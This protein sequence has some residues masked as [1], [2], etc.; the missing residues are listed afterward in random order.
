MIV[1]TD[2]LVIGGGMAAAW[3]AISAAREG[4]DVVVVDKGFVGTSG[5]TA[6]GGPNHWWVP[7]DDA[8]RESAVER[9]Y[10]TS[11]GLADKGWMARIIDI[12]WQTLPQL[13]GYYR[14]ATDSRGQP[15]Y[16][17]V[18]GPEYL[19]ALR[20]LALESGVHIFDQHPALELLVHKD[21]SIAGAAGYARLERQ[22]WQIRAGAVILATGGCAFRSGLIGSYTNTGDGH[23]M[24][25]EVGAE[26]SGMEF[27]VAYSISPAWISTRTLPY[28]GARYYDVS[29][30]E[31]DIPPFR[32]GTAYLK[33]LA[34]AFAAGPVYADLHDAP[35]DLKSILR[36]IQP[37]TI[38]PFERKGIKI[39]EDRF[40]V[41]LFG[42]GTV[43]GTGGLKITGAHCETSI[44]GLY[45]AGDTAT[46]ELIAGATS[47]GGAQNAA[48]ALTS[49]ILSG[50]GAAHL[51][52][53]LGRRSTE[54]IKPAGAAALRPSGTAKPIDMQA[55]V[56]RVQD[57]VLPLE[58]ALWR[59]SKDLSNTSV[60]LD[61]AWREIIVYGHAEGLGIVAARETA[62]M[63]SV[64][65][66]CTAAA[67]A[68]E[69]SRGIHS[70]ADRTDTVPEYTSRLLV[71]GLDS[72]HLWTR[73]ETDTTMKAIA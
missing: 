1:D 47:G 11:C 39:F 70:R 29:G 31:L 18:R 48:W 2:V 27:N 33:A 14:F 37:A 66:L 34:K 5:V 46:R 19:R 30:Q 12:T 8:Q 56:Q 44:A 24:A 36:H 23:L 22:H 21:G 3:A 41:K 40:E 58:R 55:I 7:P 72:D 15:Y 6:T 67:L 13:A 65:R 68:R 43:R 10:A 20:N 9:R 52:R 32:S 53:R 64:A 63:T 61:E 69:E 25:G 71:G 17:G 73:Y 59:T 50:K 35:V 42:E 57:Q 4:A 28:T 49:G 51:A 60:L 62:A 54:T 45:A 38:A 16:P 26:F